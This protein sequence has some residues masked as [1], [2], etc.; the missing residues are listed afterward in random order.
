MSSWWKPVVFN[1]LKKE[2]LVFCGID[3]PGLPNEPVIT[4]KIAYYRFHGNPRLYYS[5]H[6][7]NELKRVVDLTVANKKVTESFIF[8][9]NTATTAAIKNAEWIKKHVKC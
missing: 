7:T 4:N 9:N 3:Y 5:V 2:G 1:K 8:F 6:K